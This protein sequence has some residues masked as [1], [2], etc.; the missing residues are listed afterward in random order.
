[1]GDWFSNDDGS[2]VALAIADA[3]TGPP[4][5]W[6][7][8]SRPRSPSPT[9]PSTPPPCRSTFASQGWTNQ[10]NTRINLAVSLGTDGDLSASL[11]ALQ[12]EASCDPAH[13]VSLKLAGVAR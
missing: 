6:P 7:G 1:M 4:A 12:P 11:S 8:S 13:L 2:P 3:A 9:A 10:R 5:S